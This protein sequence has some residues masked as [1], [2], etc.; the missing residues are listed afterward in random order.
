MAMLLSGCRTPS[1]PLPEADLPK[2][3]PKDEPPVT[4]TVNSAGG[5]LDRKS[6]DGKGTMQW[7]IEWESATL[8]YTTDQQFGG[9]MKNVKGVLYHHGEPRSTFVATEA[10]A[11]KGKN[12]L[13]LIGGVRVTSTS[14]QA[15]LFCGELVYDGT[16]G[17]IDA[18]KGIE[19]DYEA[20]RVRGINALRSNSDLSVVATPESYKPQP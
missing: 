8:E 12:T 6:D 17:I 13:K 9:R 15:V 7:S 10:V 4:R 19:V 16:L 20:Y 14:P 18:Q 2:G 3:D 1:V 11:D 5:K